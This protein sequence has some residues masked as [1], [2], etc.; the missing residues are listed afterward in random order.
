MDAELKTKIDEVGVAIKHVQ[1]K[2]KED[3]EKNAVDF[4]SIKETADKAAVGFE[5][6]QLK[7]QAM[8]SDELV[9]RLYGIEKALAEGKEGKEV[10]MDPEHQKSHYGYLRSGV[11]PSK[12]CVQAFCEDAAKKTLV[13]ATDEQLD[14]YTKALVSGSNADGGFFI[15]PDRSAQTIKRE[16]ETSP[17]LSIANV[18]N[19]SSNSIEMIIDDDEA[20]AGWVGEVETR[21]DS[22]T[23]EVGLITIPIHTI[24]ARPKATQNQ[25]DDAG[26]DIEGWLQGKIIDKFGRVANT[27]FTIGDGSKKPKG[28]LSYDA[29]AVAGTY[30]RDALEQFTSTGTSATL[31]EEK[32]FIT[33]QNMLKD[34]YQARAVWTMTRSTFSETMK[35]QDGVG[36]FLLNFLMMKEGTGRVLLGK[37]VK[38]FADQPEIAAN[39][40]SVA[41]GDFSVGYTVV[42]RFG[43]R[44]LRNPYS[45]EPYI[46]YSS[47]QRLGAAVT[48]FE[49]IKIM[50]TKA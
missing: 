24:F 43:I 35:L 16:F 33:L 42:N 41:Y 48:N 37:E 7:L 47:H 36:N 19:T 4:A 11:K 45:D 40:L 22:D 31:D 15:T 21:A 18:T 9:E 34:S 1:D 17:M 28:Y 49:A 39:S 5:Q 12:E 44:V 27:S 29:W 46:R 30:Q 6:I 3:G 50:K 25:I 23:P 20:D 32:D 10:S 14:A 13:H 26:F 8:K 38:I 2:V